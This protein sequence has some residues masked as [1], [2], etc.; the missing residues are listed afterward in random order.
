MADERRYNREQIE[1]E[2]EETLRQAGAHRL[3]PPPRRQVAPARGLDLRLA[4]PSQPLIAG[5]VLILL[6]WF[7]LAVF[8]DGLAGTLGLALLAFGGL[9][10]LIRPRRRE[11]YWRGRRIDWSDR[12]T[13]VERVYYLF[14]RR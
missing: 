2:I 12:P 6:E 7:R 9:S 4:S 1:R 11:T 13:P 3:P 8:L 14:Y 10:W 5:G